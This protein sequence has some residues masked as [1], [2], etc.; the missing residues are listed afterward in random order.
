MIARNTEM[1][2]KISER[3]WKNVQLSYLFEVRIGYDIIL[4]IKMKPLIRN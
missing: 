3:L 2:F 4:D 1:Y